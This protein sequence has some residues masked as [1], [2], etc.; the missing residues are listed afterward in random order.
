M[1]P[2]AMKWDHTGGP[3]DRVLLLLWRGPSIP[4]F[5]QRRSRPEITGITGVAAAVCFAADGRNI[6]RP[7]KK[8]VAS[9]A[10]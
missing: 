10:R 5:P 9:M 8:A 1:K 7:K 6:I 3:H 2:T 4:G